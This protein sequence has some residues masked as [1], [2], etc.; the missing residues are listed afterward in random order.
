MVRRGKRD[1]DGT[2]GLGNGAYKSLKL[3]LS[4]GSSTCRLRS[5]LPKPLAI[6]LPKI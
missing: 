6:S 5:G 1:S 4:F 3:T 2:C